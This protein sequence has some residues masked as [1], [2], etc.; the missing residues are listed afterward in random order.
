M[1]AFLLAVAIGKRIETRRNSSLAA[2]QSYM[3]GSMLNELLFTQAGKVA[4]CCLRRWRRE[5][6]LCRANHFG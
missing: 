4:Q 1:H 6:I 3:E 5:T 2:I